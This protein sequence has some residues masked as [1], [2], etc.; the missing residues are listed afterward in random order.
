MSHKSTTTKIKTSRSPCDISEL[1]KK[2]DSLDLDSIDE[3]QGKTKAQ[4]TKNPETGKSIAIRG[5]TFNKLLNSGKWGWDESN[6]TF[7]SKINDPTISSENIDN[8]QPKTTGPSL[9]P[10]DII[11]HTIGPEKG[12]GRLIK[13]IIHITDTHIPLKLF[14]NE[15]REQEYLKVFSELYSK[16]KTVIGNSDRDDFIIV[17]TGDLSH[18]KLDMQAETTLMARNFLSELALLADVVIIIG[19]HD[20]AENNVKR[21]DTMTV[22]CDRLSGVYMLKNTGLYQLGNILFSFSS[23]FFDGKFIKHG[24]IIPAWTGPIYALFHGTILGSKNCN[25]TRNEIGIGKGRFFSVGDFSGYDGVLLGHIHLQQSMALNIAYAGSLIQQDRGEPIEGHGFLIWTVGVPEPVFQPIINEYAFIDVDIT[26]GVPDTSHL[27]RYNKKKLKIRMNLID[28][29]PTQYEDALIKLNKSY[30]IIDTK[31]GKSNGGIKPDSTISHINRGSLMEQEIRLIKTMADEKLREDIIQLHEN[32]RRN[33]PVTITRSC[34]SWRPLT[35]KFRNMFNYGNNR[36]NTV[37]FDSG[38]HNLC[39]RNKSGKTSICRLI[40][41]ALYGKPHF[42]NMVNDTNP[43]GAYVELILE[44]SNDKYRIRRTYEL[45]KGKTDKFKLDFCKELK[46][47]SEQKL[48]GKAD[49]STE[50]I[51]REYVGEYKLFTLCNSINRKTQAL[52]DML[53]TDRLNTLHSLCGTNQYETLIE[54]CKD[55]RQKRQQELQD[56]STQAKNLQQTLNNLGDIKTM[57]NK[58]PILN[59]NLDTLNIKL[60]ELTEKQSLTISNKAIA[61]AELKDIRQ[62]IK[63]VPSKPDKTLIILNEE[64]QATQTEIDSYEHLM[65]EI[66]GC[67]ESSLRQNIQTLKRSINYKNTKGEPNISK[68]DEEIERTKDLL[69]EYSEYIPPSGLNKDSLGKKIALME[70]SLSNYKTQLSKIKSNPWKETS[71]TFENLCSRVQEV[72]AEY[73][74]DEVKL[75]SLEQ[76]VSVFLTKC[77]INDSS[78]AINILQTLKFIDETD[79]AQINRLHINSLIAYIKATSSKEFESITRSKLEISQ[80]KSNLE[81]NKRVQSVERDNLIIASQINWLNYKKTLANICNLEESLAETEKASTYFQAIEDAKIAQSD[82]ENIDSIEQL[83][84]QLKL[85]SLLGRMKDIDKHINIWNQI[86]STEKD[87]LRI[88]KLQTKIDLFKIKENEQKRE[89]FK[90]GKERDTNVQD[91]TKL[92]LSIDQYKEYDQKLAELREPIPS[93]EEEIAIRVEYEKI[94]HREQIPLKILNHKMGQFNVYINNIF[95]KYTKYTVKAET[96]EKGLQFLITNKSS[97]KPFDSD[98]IC[99]YE[100]IVLQI[101]INQAILN[102]SETYKCSFISID[103]NFDCIDQVNFQNELPIII[104]A[105]REAYSTVLLISHR[106]LPEDSINRTLK[107]CNHGTY[108]T[109][110]E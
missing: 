45:S 87:Q 83:T 30:Q 36:D 69:S 60:E 104:K 8:P 5:T 85:L 34:A 96:E 25:G 35:L 28:T 80:A 65:D 9:V 42:I 1:S 70:A 109:I 41:F 48:N 14:E 103:E 26:N 21:T 13:K 47:G 92:T 93:L 105:M 22:I 81:H 57:E 68:I 77:P 86:E 6:L 106:D 17:H 73:N 32:L 31:I 55:S 98:A 72:E 90:L 43:T 74:V 89:I 53:P 99:G 108:S 16:I 82:K 88:E 101:A 46:D 33:Q 19:N 10:E 23:I 24:D 100:S 2:L 20:L 7:S 64:K 38:V 11:I 110:N 94:F 49:T 66:D 29:T 3:K 97:G 76:K 51:I 12:K 95:E 75:K 102:I 67:T 4:K 39:A 52:I 50:K 59:K 15:H 63:T 54:E 40:Q 107:I 79:S 56:C 44:H 84:D 18:V 61:E 27:D 71:E 62:N 37:N 91:I 58:L 78:E